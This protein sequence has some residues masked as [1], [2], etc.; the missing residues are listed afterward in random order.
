MELYD[1][2]LYTFSELVSE[3]FD[4]GLLKNCIFKARRKERYF[5]YELNVAL[6]L[7]VYL[8]CCSVFEYGTSK[9]RGNMRTEQKKGIHYSF[10]FV[11][12]HIL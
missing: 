3:C 9:P 11:F 10:K 1:A 2:E 6:F 4:G 8:L 12:S 5:H 7:E